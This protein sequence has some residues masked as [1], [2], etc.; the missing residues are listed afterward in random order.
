MLLTT[1]EALGMCSCAP[2]PA[3]PTPLS[4]HRRASR[5]RPAP[6]QITHVA[7]YPATTMGFDTAP[8]VSLGKSVDAI[9][10]GRQGDRHAGRRDA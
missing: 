8:G 3:Q 4:A 9:R 1:P 7:Q 5:E 10:A 6:L 2:A